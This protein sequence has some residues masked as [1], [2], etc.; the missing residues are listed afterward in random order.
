[1][2]VANLYANVSIESMHFVY[3][4]VPI[5]VTM[6]KYYMVIKC[7]YWAHLIDQCAAFVG[8]IWFKQP[9]QKISISD[10]L[11]DVGNDVPQKKHAT[12]RAKID[13]PAPFEIGEDEATR[14]NG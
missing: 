1:M 8:T 13:M 3:A 7:A 11:H 10:H 2:Q 12:T 6:I 5:V 9:A 4:A 14:R